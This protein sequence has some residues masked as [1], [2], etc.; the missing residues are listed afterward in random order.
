MGKYPKCGP[1]KPKLSLKRAVFWLCYTWVLTWV[2]TAG[3]STKISLL[4]GRIIDPH[5]CADPNRHR[6]SGH[7][8]GVAV[9]NDRGKLFNSAFSKEFTDLKKFKILLFNWIPSFQED[10]K[11]LILESIQ[12]SYLNSLLSTKMRA[13]ANSLF[14]LTSWTKDFLIVKHINF[15][16]FSLVCDGFRPWFSE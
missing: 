1:K 12:N 6:R 4:S 16:Y 2:S 15:V 8:S 11:G 3:T 14:I 7:W 13:K 10:T 9:Y 5:T